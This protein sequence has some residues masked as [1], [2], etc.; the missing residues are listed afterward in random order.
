MLTYIL[1]RFIIIDNNYKEAK[2]REMKKGTVYIGYDRL[3]DYVVFD[4]ETTGLSGYNDRI[5]QIAAL[6]IKDGKVADT[7]AELINPQKPISE[8]IEK[9]TGITN[10][11]VEDKETYDKVLPRFYQ[12]IKDEDLVAHNAEFDYDRFLVRHMEQINIVLNNRT[13]CTVEIAKA[14]VKSVDNYK[15]K[16]LCKHFCIKLQNHHNAIC[17]VEATYQLFER[18]KRIEKDREI[19]RSVPTKYNSITAQDDSKRYSLK[20]VNLWQNKRLYFDLDI[21]SVYYDLKEKKWVAEDKVKID[22]SDI[23]KTLLDINDCRTMTQLCKK[24]RMLK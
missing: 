22:L 18:L 16:T 3:V 9:L 24:Y 20:K 17:D 1:R 19:V 13:Y 10:T 23:Q 2:D 11:M 6:K 5:I 7:F 8:K 15:L 12:F 21:G 4:I 14:L